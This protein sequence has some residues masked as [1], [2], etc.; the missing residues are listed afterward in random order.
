MAEAE[1]FARIWGARGSLPV[2]P[3]EPSI[4]G[5]NTPCVEVRC[6]RRLFVLDAGTGIFGLGRSLIGEEARAVDVLLTHCHY[7][8][9][10]GLPFFR[11]LHDTR[12]RVRLW[13]G[14]TAGRLSTESMV[15]GY[16]RQPYFPVGPWCFTSAVSYHDFMP[17]DAL[18]VGDGIT[19]RTAPLNHPGGAVGYR[20]EYRGR[21]IC[22]VTDTEHVPG[23]PDQ[24][25]LGLIRGASA[26]IYDAAYT[27]A[28]F[29]EYVGYGHSTWE[30]GVRLCE[31]AGAERL[32]AF[33]H[34][35]DGADDLLAN[36]E[37]ALV[38]KRPGSLFAREGLVLAA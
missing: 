21:S 25:I 2:A 17:G 5:A 32:V 20:F 10:E 29:P 38:K 24:N 26:V 34:R 14:H 22:Y 11:P 8:H 6:G 33:H 36:A 18:E 1:F 16:M 9:I 12:W 37:A 31:A 28:D 13:A 23:K 27:D 35:P 15:E 19:I 7:D 4:Y 3:A 30:E